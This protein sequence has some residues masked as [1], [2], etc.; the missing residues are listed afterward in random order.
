M[1]H[2]FLF[3]MLVSYVGFVSSV[4]QCMMTLKIERHGPCH[5]THKLQTLLTEHKPVTL[6][7]LAIT[8]ST[9]GKKR[10][11]KDDLNEVTKIVWNVQ[12]Y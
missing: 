3:V 9:P 4:F 6:L 8:T 11:D 2:V 5:G 7:H 1:V 10:I 12:K